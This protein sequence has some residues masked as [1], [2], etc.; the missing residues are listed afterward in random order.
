MPREPSPHQMLTPEPLPIHTTARPP[1]LS[2]L[3]PNLL[4]GPNWAPVCGRGG[5]NWSTAAVLNHTD[6]FFKYYA[7]PGPSL[8]PPGK[9]KTGRRRL[10]TLS[11]SNAFSHYSLRY[12]TKIYPSLLRNAPVPLTSWDHATRLHGGHSILLNNIVRSRTSSARD[13]V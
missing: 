12:Q 8:Q 6:P 13:V 2:F 10:P 1:I 11:M 4:G 5:L 3:V 7:C 9:T